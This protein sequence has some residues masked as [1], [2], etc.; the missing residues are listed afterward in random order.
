MPTID[1]CEVRASVLEPEV[2]GARRGAE[3]RLVEAWAKEG[4]LASEVVEPILAG[5]AARES[6][7]PPA[8]G[9]GVAAPYLRHPAVPRRLLAIA[10]CRRP[11]D[12]FTVDERPVDLVVLQLA[13]A[14]PEAGPP[15]DFG[16]RL[17][18]A[19]SDQEFRDAL[20]AAKS[21]DDVERMAIERLSGGP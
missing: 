17:F 4:L 10:V 20:R 16:Q 7:L 11:L 2:C 21:A 13:P 6:F 9:G 14:S 19:L 1:R 18:L 12:Y 8:L 5:L 3:R 15:S